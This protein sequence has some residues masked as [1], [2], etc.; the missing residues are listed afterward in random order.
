LENFLN[1]PLLNFSYV[2]SVD[3]W[4][5]GSI[6]FIA[7]SLIE[8]A[9]VGH[10]HRQKKSRGSLRRPTVFLEQEQGMIQLSRGTS[11]ATTPGGPVVRF[12]NYEY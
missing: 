7:S 2:M 3:V 10:L 6:A 11:G 4:I 5:F 8:L 9:I 1:L 12:N